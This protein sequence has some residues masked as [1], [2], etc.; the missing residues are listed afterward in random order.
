MVGQL[1]KLV[2][3]MRDARHESLFFNVSRYDYSNEILG[4]QE[5]AETINNIDAEG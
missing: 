2:K 4:F 1:Y 5:D 3:P